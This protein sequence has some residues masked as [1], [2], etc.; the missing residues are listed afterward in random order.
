MAKI[1]PRGKNTAWYQQEEEMGRHQCKNSF[2]NL[3]CN[4]ITPEPND[5]TMGRLDYPNQE[6]AEEND[7]IR[8]METFKEEMKNSL[9]EMVEK[10]NKTLEE[11]NKSLK[12]TQEK[13]MK[14]VKQTVKTVQDLKTEIEA[15]K[16]TQTK[17][18][19]NM[20]NLGK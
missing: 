14:C 15:R 5:H 11:T 10:T 1:G 4:R 18:I 3:K 19:L 8:T 7:F 12:E 9:K 6:E 20:E 17:G 2:N 16:G 13:T